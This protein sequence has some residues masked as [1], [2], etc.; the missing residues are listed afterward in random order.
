MPV[1]LCVFQVEGTGP[2]SLEIYRDGSFFR[3]ILHPAEAGPN[4][5]F[6]TSAPVSLV[7]LLDLEHLPVL[8]MCCVGADLERA[9]MLC[10]VL[11]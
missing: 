3:R 4:F 1:L 2:W 11:F 8:S 7:A 9:A 10:R 5:T 6:S